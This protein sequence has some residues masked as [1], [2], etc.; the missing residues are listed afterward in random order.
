MRY[1]DSSVVVSLLLQ[2]ATTG[3]VHRLLQGLVDVE[4]AISDWGRLEVLSVLAQG[5]RTGALT[6]VDKRELFGRLEV[7]IRSSLSVLVPSA[8]DYGEAQRFVRT[9]EAALRGGDA[10]HLA[11]A[12]N[13]GADAI[14]TLDKGMLKAGRLLGLPVERGF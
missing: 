4:L 5:F 7:L 3:A 1:L 8:A 9:P 11:I 13:H 2:E 10:L 12:A 14:Y 6:G